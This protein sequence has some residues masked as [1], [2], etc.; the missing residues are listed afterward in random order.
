M[1]SH[2]VS[3]L[4]SESKCARS[5]LPLNNKG[6]GSPLEALASA[7]WN[8]DGSMK[9]DQ[10]VAVDLKKMKIGAFTPALIALYET[11]AQS[12]GLTKDQIGVCKTGSDSLHALLHR[13][14][15]TLKVCTQLLSFLAQPPPT[16]T[17]FCSYP[18]SY[19]Y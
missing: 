8:V 1:T 9:S 15:K 18:R 10:A 17:F 6:E 5:A 14:G 12:Q 16:T 4:V 11:Y 7:V 3:S 13:P 2:N 19:H